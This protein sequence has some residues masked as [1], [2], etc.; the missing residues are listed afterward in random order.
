MA[1]TR[2]TTCSVR[3]TEISK[4]DL[5]EV[6]LADGTVAERVVWKAEGDLVFVCT[7]KTYERLLR[8]ADAALPIAFPL[9][10]VRALARA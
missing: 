4:G 2:R 6:A 9:E 10:D 7:D 1:I 5:V 3:N 8:G